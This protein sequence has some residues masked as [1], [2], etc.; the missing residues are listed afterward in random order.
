MWRQSK[1]KPT[2]IWGEEYSRH[3]NRQCKVIEYAWHVGEIGR[4]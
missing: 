4:S 3:G 2:D 1:I